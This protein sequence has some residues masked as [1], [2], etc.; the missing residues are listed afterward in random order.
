MYDIAYV[1]GKFYQLTNIGVAVFRGD[2]MIHPEHIDDFYPILENK[3]LRKKIVELADQRDSP[4]L[5]Q[6][7]HGVAFA[8][9]KRDGD[10]IFIGPMSMNHLSR[11]ELHRFYFDNG[12]RKGMEKQIPAMNLSRILA[13]VEL[14]AAFILGKDYSDDELLRENEIFDETKNQ[15]KRIQDMM[16][17]EMEENS[18]HT[19]IE[20]R[21]LLNCVREGRV[22]DAL[23]MNAQMDTETG[24]MSD[25]AAEQVRKLVIVAIALTTRAAIEGG[26]SPASAYDV[27]DYY[28]RQLDR[29][30]RPAE[31]LNIRNQAVRELTGMVHRR[32]TQKASSSYVEQCC[33]Y[34]NKH[35]REKIYLEDIANQ[36]NLSPSYLSRLFKKEKGLNIQDYI[37]Q[38]RVD[39]AANLLKYSDESIAEIGDYV[40]FPSQSYF[41]RIFKKYKHMTPGKFRE[42][43]KPREF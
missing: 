37:V 15:E 4:A 10:Y 16:K 38:I 33:D 14:L 39:R 35:Y 43:Y 20:E 5:Y 22:E 8:C 2:Q 31:W 3:T 25:N 17:Q 18:H 29:T 26:V 21:S 40:N 12:M 1:F 42:L 28:N 11:V 32:L 9:I 13:A 34:I 41:G 23:R 19:Y 24:V 7:S 30:K 6:D 36:L 27:S